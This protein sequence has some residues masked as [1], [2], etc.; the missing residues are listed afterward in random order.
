MA[1]P[2]VEKNGDGRP[3]NLPGVYRH[4]ETGKELIARRHRKFGDAQADGF[5]QVGYKWVG[6]EP[7]AKKAEKPEEPKSVQAPKEETTK[8]KEGK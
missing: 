8:E 6:P 4:P 2:K 7:K 3:A 5:V 1:E